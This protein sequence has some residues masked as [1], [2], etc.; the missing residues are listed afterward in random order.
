[1]DTQLCARTLYSKSQILRRLLNTLAL[2]LLLSL[3]AVPATAQAVYGSVFG[4][5]T[6]TTGAVIPGAKITVTD[7]SKNTSVT[8]VTNGSGE[9]RVEHLIP[10]TYRVDA[11]ASGFSQG[12][13]SNVVVFA[14]TSPK[15]D[16]QLKIGA[17]SN[18]VTVTAGA[19]LLQTDREDVSTILNT[20]ALTTLPNLQRNF[21]SFELLTPGTNYIGWSVGQSTN[22][23]QSEQIE[24]NGQLPFA[25]G[26]ELDGTNNQDPIEGVAVINPNLDAVSEMK[27]TSQN[28][29][30]EFGGAVAGM[31]TAQTK[32]GS[33][34]F[35]GSLFEYRR[36]DAQQARN[37]FN[38]IGPNS[39]PS[40]LHNQFGGSIGGPILKNKLFFFGDYQ[41]LREKTGTTILTTV[42]TATAHSSCTS[43]GDCDLSDYLN[44]ALGGGPQY[45][46]YDPESNPGGTSA[47]TAFAG[48]IIPAGRLSAPSIAL[49]KE[50]PLPNFGN[51]SIF[52]NFAGSGSGG[53]NTDQ[54]DVRIDEQISEKFHSFGRYTRF[55]SALDGAPVFGAA[56]GP[57]FGLGNFAGTDHALDQNVAAGGDYALSTKWLTDF[58]FGW[59]RIHINEVAPDFNQPLGTQL[60]IPGVNQG[61]L[62]IS[63]GLPQFGISVPANG[64]NGSAVV[65]YGTTANLF[66]QTESQYQFVNNWSHFLGNHNIRFGADIRYALNHLV[67]VNNNNLPSGMFQFPGTVTA[68]P[69]SQGLGYATFALGD[70][71]NFFRTVI[72][73]TNAAERQRRWFFYGQDQWRATQRLTVNYGVR[74]DLYFPETVAGKGQGGLL[75]LASGNVRV[76]GY[77]PYNNSMNVNMEYSHV[78]PRIGLAWQV[79]PNTVVRAGYGRA[80]G[81]GWS[82]DIF[83]EVLTFSY[84]TAIVQNNTAPNQ[85]Y[86]VFNLSA[87]PP[88][89]VFPPIPSNGDF[90]LPNGIGLPTRPLTIRI[91]TLDAWNFTIQQQ[92][93][94][95]TSLQIGYIGSHGVHNMFDSSNQ[96][97]V[98]QQTLTGFNCSGAPIGCT[99][100]I[101][102]DTGLPYTTFERMPYYDGTAQSHLGVTFGVPHGWTQSFRYNANQATTKYNA[103]QVVFE[104]RYSHGFQVLS[105]YTW[106]QA[107]ANE[108]DYFFM[109][110]KADFG[111][112]YYNRRNVFVFTGNWDLPFGK[113][114]ALG[115]AVPGV[116]NQL[117]GGFALN[118]T[119]RWESGIPFTPSYS[120]CTQDQDIDPQGGTLCRP[121]ALGTGPQATLHAEPLNPVSHTV[122]YF[123]PVPTLAFA[124]D[125]QGPYQRPNPGTFGDMERDSLWGPGLI[126][127]DAAVSKRFFLTESMNFQLQAQ[128]F[129]LFNHPNLGNP[130]G[131]VDC[132]SSSGIISGIVA[133]QEGTTMRRLQFSARFQF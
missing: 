61:D 4:T 97:N 74:W 59:F 11:E 46:A 37:P 123:Q 69:G 131:C 52:D 75:D 71:N 7:V 110:S 56:G 107:R 118:G 114:K 55:N 47:R 38:Q 32:S 65:S 27:V 104:E 15:V 125:V 25:T 121:N 18:T 84:P 1:M 91:P 45:Q 72:Q 100:P 17:V 16:I 5:V 133:S 63:G 79:L 58:R 103:L 54:F 83:G 26:Y 128:A 102:P 126:N 62:A 50:I 6:D 13:A 51:G 60:G 124:G 130:N 115:A 82:G 90:P 101:D 23:Q 30:A 3:A 127:V 105:H 80:Y 86:Y 98:N 95:S 113:G 73:N 39:I 112:S 28:Y 119:W 33:N 122:Q 24:V 44:P 8:T 21:T 20:R 40:F 48:N 106:S 94:R 42:P 68:G 85:N 19:P 120:L 77:G 92:L 9:Y 41:G 81:M 29:T 53:F 31:V 93:S 116:V 76:A 34:H 129:N 36:S 99:V 57:G 22:P 12:S 109:D 14:D 66:Q 78:A 35:H 67:G 96:A 49:M 43:G 70:V 64:S 117:I 132:G 88:T 2:S 111:N 89:F 10:D 87:G 108:S